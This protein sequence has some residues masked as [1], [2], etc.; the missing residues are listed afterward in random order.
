M[1]ENTKHNNY[2][3]E[4]GDVLNERTIELDISGIEQIIPGENGPEAPLGSIPR[5]KGW[6][7]LLSFTVTITIICAV[8]IF[9]LTSVYQRGFLPKT[10]NEPAVSNEIIEKGEV[11]GN[12]LLDFEPLNATDSTPISAESIILD[13]VENNAPVTDPKNKITPSRAPVNP[14][15][16]PQVTPGPAPSYGHP[17]TTKPDVKEPA[18][19]KEEPL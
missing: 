9:L 1:D 4:D 3:P 12:Q 16:S 18:P 13:G 5:K 2:L 8:S 17:P 7:A 10:Q 15:V 6:I 14:N 11:D 19:T